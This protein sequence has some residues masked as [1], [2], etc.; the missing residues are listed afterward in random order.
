[1]S[2]STV[3]SSF[4]LPY[5]NDGSKVVSSH[6]GIQGFFKPELDYQVGNHSIWCNH[7][8]RPPQAFRVIF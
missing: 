6:L 1:M 4:S 7:S 5:N 2:D 3:A 8:T